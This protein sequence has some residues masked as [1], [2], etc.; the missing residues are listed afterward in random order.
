MDWSI[1][2]VCKY[3]QGH[4]FDQDVVQAFKTNHI[5]GFTFISALNEEALKKDL[6][7]SS[8]GY[9]VKLLRLRQQLQAS[10]L[11]TDSSAFERLNL[12]WG[13]SRQ[14]VPIEIY[15]CISSSLGEDHAAAP[16]A[17]NNNKP[18]LVLKPK[19]TRVFLHFY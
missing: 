3:L 2:Q 16:S 13:K 17:I 9:R 18:D 11:Q 10:S 19:K 4:G 5:D 12:P 14:F 6:E 1:E 7:I 8:M 15:P